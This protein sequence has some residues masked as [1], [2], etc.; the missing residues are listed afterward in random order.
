MHDNQSNIR[1]KGEDPRSPCASV[2][3][4]SHPWRA[5]IVLIILAV[6]AALTWTMWLNP[7]LSQVHFWVISGDSWA[8][9]AAGR[10]VS[11]GAYP[12][13]YQA[14]NTWVAGPLLPVLL[15]PIALIQDALKLTSR[16]TGGYAFDIGNRSL[17]ISDVPHP[18]VWVLYGSYTMVL[19]SVLLVAVRRRAWD[20]LS[21]QDRSSSSGLP[22]AVQVVVTVLGVSAAVAY[23]MHAEDAL[24]VAMLLFAIGSLW[25]GRW[26][27]AA[28]CGGVAISFKQWT[29]LP[30]LLMI[31]RV[32][33][34]ERTRFLLIGLG[35]PGV[36]YG[37]PLLAAPGATMK[38][39]FRAGS[40]PWLGHAAPWITHPEMPRVV[41]ATLGRV[42]WLAI[43]GGGA[44]L[45]RKRGDRETLL[46][47]TALVLTVRMGT[48]SVVYSYYLFGIVTFVALLE[49]AQRRSVLRTTIV[50]AA[51]MSWFW[52]PPQHVWW[53]FV[54]LGLLGVLVWPAVRTVF[55]VRRQ[56][57]EVAADA[58]AD[59]CN[60]EISA[61]ASSR[62]RSLPAVA[63]SGATARQRSRL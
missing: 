55:R 10:Y 13:L 56:D 5:M 12:Y 36:L 40:G 48:E 9:L 3:R 44:W 16:T 46:A 39:L 54:E 58:P 35:I 15:A 7:T 43:A 63:D 1:M 42:L 4:D 2:P 26:T 47:A 34:G 62:G 17:A 59:S 30:A 61:S 20:L 27:T 6:G 53:W 51:A 57:E 50:G 52:V 11:A 22:L 24:G 32:P 49:V 45:L 38:A 33:K 8:P 23:Y 25:R 60:E 37:I 19:S 18:T 28:I 21:P 41:T 31:A 29:A 14:D